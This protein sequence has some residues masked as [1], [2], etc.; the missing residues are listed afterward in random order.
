MGSE[1]IMHIAL[2]KLLTYLLPFLF[3]FLRIG[4]FHVQGGGRK[5][6]P[7]LALVYFVFISIF[8]CGCMFAFVVLDLVLSVLSQEIG[9]EERL[10]NDL[11]CVR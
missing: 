5:G 4:P 8:C 11:F 9:W 10:Q 2:Y 1:A 6:R 3:T 7:I